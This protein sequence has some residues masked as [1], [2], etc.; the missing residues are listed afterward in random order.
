MY[1]RTIFKKTETSL[2]SNIDS[3]VEEYFYSI[4][5]ELSPC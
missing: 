3:L 4:D 5:S 2:D 1:N